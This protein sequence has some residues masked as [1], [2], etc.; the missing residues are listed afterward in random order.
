MAKYD[1]LE[2]YNQDLDSVT[3]IQRLG[4]HLVGAT[5]RSFVPITFHCKPSNHCPD[6]RWVDLDGP[7]MPLLLT[8]PSTDVALPTSHFP[9]FPLSALN[10]QYLLKPLLPTPPI[11]VE[12]YGLCL[13]C[14]VLE[15]IDDM[16]M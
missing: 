2:P 15:C 4:L 11:K 16:V 12:W 8:P 10:T 13:L 6:L 7:P 5:L 3:D 1:R 9:S 14:Y